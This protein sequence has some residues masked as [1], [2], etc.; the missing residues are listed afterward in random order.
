MIG[1][2]CFLLLGFLLPR[3]TASAPSGPWDDFNYAPASRIVYPQRIYDT[4]GDV[5]HEDGLLLADANPTTLS[6]A[7]AW[8]TIDFGKEVRISSAQ[9]FACS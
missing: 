1:P 6:G 7:D 9:L 4:N 8:V 3:T 5:E 2:T